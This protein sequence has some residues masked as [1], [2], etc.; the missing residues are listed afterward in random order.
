MNWLLLQN[1]LL[2]ALATTLASG[3]L[4]TLVAV[5]LSGL[6]P[7]WRRAA[8][9]ATVMSLALPP[10]L[11]TN[12]WLD[13]VGQTGSWRAWFPIPIYSL[14][15]TIWI[16]TLMLW[17]LTALLVWGSLQKLEACQ[18]EGE[19]ALRGWLMLR[20][21]LG[22]MARP[23]LSQAALVTFV[24]AFNNFAVPA[25]L[26]TKVFPAELW[27][28]FNTTFDYASV[29]KLSCP[30]LLLS[31][32]LWLCLRSTPVTWPRI[33][34]GVSG[35]LFRRHLGMG[36]YGCATVGSVLLLLLAVGLPVGALLFN[37]RTWA[38]LP[39][40]LA[41][42][43][44]AL[45]NSL[46]FA[47]LSASLCV[48]GG[49]GLW[50]FRV[51][52]VLWIPFLLP[53]VLLGIALIFAF[54]RSGT[55]LF[56]Q[57]AGIVVLALTARYLALAWSGARQAMQTIDG[58]WVDFARLNG[59]GRWQ[60]FRHVFWP[61]IAAD[62]RG[63]WLIT[64]LLCLWDVETLVLVIPPGS[65][66]LALRV[67]NLLHYGHNVEVNALCVLLLGLAALGT[68]A[69]AAGERWLGSPRGLNGRGGLVLAAMA[70]LFTG[71]CQPASEFTPLNSQLFSSVQVVGSRG[72][73][74]GQFNKP[75][76]LAIDAHDNLY[77]VDM[78]GRVQKFSSNGTFLAFWQMP[79]TEKGKPKGMC[80]DGEGNIV[81]VEPHY[82]R[83]NH[84]TPEGKLVSQW[85]VAGTNTGQLCLP[86]AATVD[87]HGDILVCEYTLVDR[88]Q[89]FASHGDIWKLAFGHSGRGEG[90]LNRPEGLGVD[91][92]GQIYVAD[93]CNHRIQVYS[94]EGQFRR[95]Y[96]Q[97][98]S[99]PGQ[100]SYPY[101]VQVDADGRQYVAEFGN[102]RIQVFDRQGASIEIL[103]GGGSAPGQFANP[104]SLVLDSAGSLYVADSQNHRVQKF[105]RKPT[106]Q[107]GGAPAIAAVSPI[108][109]VASADTLEPRNSH[110]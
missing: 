70:L 15:G 95:S 81:V 106:D 41:A 32:L 8:T 75:R 12:S 29:V 79:A 78:T 68:V 85:G 102:S 54:N 20:W 4:G 61:Q 49:F 5:W 18:L 87:A 6:S 62:A 35:R 82:T 86:R 76:S 11:V 71:G 73:G 72:T 65:E 44:P 38:E 80:R 92:S 83:V 66:T 57:S 69:W 88:V 99:G 51:G 77:V 94:G 39:T 34:G 31:L 107:A 110:R 74:L 90:E 7:Q 105:L 60:S 21:L 1:S 16:L 84:F 10:F 2:V 26:Q 103:G 67:F 22:P 46:W 101:D 109:R 13:L 108:A 91:R 56:Y 37:R 33:R 93:S 53:G 28:S 9:L 59:A 23:G 25:I 36:W 97:A 55:V 3:L 19:P 64:Y 98:G 89:K 43:H 27:V 104:W 48:V 47:F 17:P 58:H 52:T 30:L 96:G 14:G 24:L 50:R 63:L 40:A 42:G 100:L 45:F